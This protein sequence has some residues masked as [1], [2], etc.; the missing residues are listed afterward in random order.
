MSSY[1]LTAACS[2]TPETLT[3]KITHRLHNLLSY[4]D[5]C[6]GFAEIGLP[7]LTIKR[8]PECTIGDLPFALVYP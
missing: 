5:R 8:F 7:S 6:Q 3:L 2:I 1:T 4:P